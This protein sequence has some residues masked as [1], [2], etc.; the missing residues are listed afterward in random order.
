M[1]QKLKFRVSGHDL[2]ISKKDVEHRLNT[3]KEQRITKVYVEVGKKEFPVK[4]AFAEIG[5]AKGLIKSSFTT[6]DA[7]RVFNGLGFK[8]GEKKKP[9]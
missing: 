4:Q 1:P 5:K 3:I 2:S 7:V 8:V 9:G 6:Q